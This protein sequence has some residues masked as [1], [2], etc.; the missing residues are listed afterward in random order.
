MVK[1]VVLDDYQGVALSLADWSRFPPGTE[2]T[3]LSHN[4][5]GK[6]EIIK[7][8]GEFEVISAM[9]ER[10]VF[11]ADILNQLPNLKL[12][13]TTG[14]RNASID[15]Y[16]ATEL[17]ILVCGTEGSTQSTSELTWG[18]ILALLRHIPEENMSIR[19]GEWQKTVGNSLEGKTLGVLGLGRLGSQVAMIGQAFGMSV[20]T[21]SQNLTE[22]RALEFNAELVTK[23]T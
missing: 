22:E 16:A 20:I 5:E 7:Q 17:G 2:I 4:I 8:L 1:I 3:V 6:P 19:K 14:M 18:L 23:D 13:V 11:S 21:W 10:T 15:L 12:L 9:R